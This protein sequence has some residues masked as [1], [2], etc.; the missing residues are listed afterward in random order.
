MR[1][2]GCRLPAMQPVEVI[3]PAG[4]LADGHAVYAV[5]TDAESSEDEGGSPEP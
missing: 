4:Q 5:C 3:K 2:T 1:S